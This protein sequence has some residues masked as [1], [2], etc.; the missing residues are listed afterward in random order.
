[1]IEGY[2]V[3]EKKCLVGGH[4]LNHLGDERLATALYPGDELADAGMSGLVRE[5][6]QAAFDQILLVGGQIETRALL[7]ELT[8]ILIV[9]GR[10]DRSPANRRSSFGA[11]WF[12]GRIAAQIPACAA[13]PGMPHTTLVASS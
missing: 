2:L 12:R 4:R 10:H 6:N 5:R 9:R 11:I 1:M 13:A 7:Q 3:A 8:Q